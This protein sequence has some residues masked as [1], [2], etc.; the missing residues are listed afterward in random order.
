MYAYA[1]LK[2]KKISE[3]MYI[4]CERMRVRVRVRMRR[5]GRK[6]LKRAISNFQ[7]FSPSL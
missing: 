5:T 3:H 4:L 6:I 7:L 2:K 1:D